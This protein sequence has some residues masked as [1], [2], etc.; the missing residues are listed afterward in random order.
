LDVWRGDP[1]KGFES[2]MNR[3][4]EQPESPQEKRKDNKLFN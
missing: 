3:L 2:M 4:K 1:E